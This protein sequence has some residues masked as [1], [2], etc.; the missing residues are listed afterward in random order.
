MVSDLFS[1][2]LRWASIGL[3]SPMGW[4]A[5]PSQET[6]HDRRHFLGTGTMT[7]AAAQLGTIGR[8]SYA[9]TCSDGFD[10]DLRNEPGV[11]PA[12]S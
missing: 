9:I 8:R 11:S 10:V 2:G 3:T 5:Y 4:K 12:L 1:T 6:N 7:I